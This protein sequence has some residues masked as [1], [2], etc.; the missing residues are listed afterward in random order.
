MKVNDTAIIAFM[1]SRNSMNSLRVL[2]AEDGVDGWM[3]FL[4]FMGMASAGMFAAEPRFG[5]P[6]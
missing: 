1:A 5:Q 2:C 4:K 3:Y 6:N